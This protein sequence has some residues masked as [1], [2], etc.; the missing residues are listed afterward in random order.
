MPYVWL[1]YAPHRV[2][3][4]AFQAWM[5]SAPHQAS[6]NTCQPS[7]WAKVK[8]TKE[9]SALEPGPCRTLPLPS[10]QVLRID[11]WNSKTSS[12]LKNSS[13][14]KGFPP[15]AVLAFCQGKEKKNQP[16]V[17]SLE[18]EVGRQQMQ[19]CTQRI[20]LK[21]APAAPGR[22]AS[23]SCALGPPSPGA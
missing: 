11:Q 6:L 9:T 13:Q 15:R 1:K 17:N 8:T 19:A 7:M 18:W 23:A 2:S 5:T 14:N 12:A 10:C 3:S 4:G 22:E 21:P 20:R 16:R